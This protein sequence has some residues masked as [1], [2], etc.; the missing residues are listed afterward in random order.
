MEVERN[1]LHPQVVRTRAVKARRGQPVPPSSQSCESVENVACR[2]LFRRLPELQSRLVGS[3]QEPGQVT[4]VFRLG[5]FDRA[6]LSQA[7]KEFF[8][9]TGTG[10]RIM[11]EVPDDE[12]GGPKQSLQVK[13]T[14][15]N[16]KRLARRAA[17]RVR[18]ERLD[19]SARTSSSSAAVSTITSQDRVR[20]RLSQEVTVCAGLVRNLA[21][22]V[23]NEE[24]RKLDLRPALPLAAKRPLRSMP[25][26]K[27]PACGNAP[28]WLRRR[29]ELALRQQRHIGPQATQNAHSAERQPHCLCPGCGREMEST[30]LYCP[31]CTMRTARYLQAPL[32]IHRGQPHQ[33]LI[34]LLSQAVS[35]G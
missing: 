21:L 18:T 3:S 1:L 15:A 34:W 22:A 31:E 12:P 5:Y 27:K 9:E 7:R 24:G 11:V 20:T 30:L 4:F 14:P 8:Q 33:S 25:K 6:G 10:L 13:L 2:V 16:L 17:A 32:S 23:R 19:R 26:K 29:E 35:W 28:A